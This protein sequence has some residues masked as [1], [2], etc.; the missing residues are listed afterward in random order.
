MEPVVRQSSQNFCRLS[1]PISF[2]LFSPSVCG[3]LRWSKSD[4]SSLSR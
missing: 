4:R 2:C 3:G 1:P